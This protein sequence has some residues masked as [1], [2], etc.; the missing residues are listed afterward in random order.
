LA[1]CGAFSPN[2]KKFSG[3]ADYWRSSLVN[4]SCEELA[5]KRK[6]EEKRDAGFHHVEHEGNEGEARGWYG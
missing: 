4:E 2:G 3:F 6:K 5:A 1:L